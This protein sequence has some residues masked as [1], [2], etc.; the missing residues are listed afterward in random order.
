MGESLTAVGD[1]SGDGTDEIIITARKLTSGAMPPYLCLCQR[2]HTKYG[3]CRR[4][5]SIVSP[6]ITTAQ[7]IGD[8]N[9]DGYRD[10]VIHHETYGTAN[11]L[12]TIYVINGSASFGETTI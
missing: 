3:E 1:V 9:G 11:E 7:G 6:Y 8:F 12:G 5:I 4:W 2:F 10:F